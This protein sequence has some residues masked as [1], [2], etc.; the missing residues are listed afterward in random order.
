MF[1]VVPLMGRGMAGSV[2]DQERCFVAICSLEKGE[3]M[4]SL[5]E[6]HLYLDTGFKPENLGTE[7]AVA[8]KRSGRTDEL[9]ASNVNAFIPFYI[10]FERRIMPQSPSSMSPHSLL[11]QAIRQ[12]LSLQN[13]NE[14]L[15][16]SYLEEIPK[17]WERMDDLI[18]LQETAFDS[19]SWSEILN[20]VGK[21]QK[22]NLWRS[23]AQS[24]NAKRLARQ[25][26]IA[27]TAQRDSRTELLLGETGWVEFTDHGVAFG[28]DSTRVMFSSGNV[29]ERRRIGNI[30]MENETIVDAYAGVGYYTLHMAQRSNA[31]QVH[32]CELNPHSLTGLKWAIRENNLQDKITVHAGDNQATLP[33]LYGIADRCHLGLLPSSKAVWKHALCCLKT[34]GGWIHV[35]MN[36][37]EKNLTQWRE[38][39]LLELHRMSKEIGR[40]WLIEAHHL[41]KVKWYSPRV[42]HVVLD[43]QCSEI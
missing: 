7:L 37:E 41:E 39:T 20:S 14:D 25:H 17:K 27:K 28:F 23:V 8:I 1:K 13:L 43:V 6:Q 3:E 2:Q 21:E 36:V 15:C 16:Q 29:T 31:K 11:E 30:S 40:E 12:W 33:S 38:D 32:A 10:R 35:H 22:T 4:Y 5:L 24:L 26:P 34:S 19:P 9:I 42:R 18:I